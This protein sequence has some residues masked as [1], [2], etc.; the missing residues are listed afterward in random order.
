MTFSNLFKPNHRK[1]QMACHWAA[2]PGSRWRSLKGCLPTQRARTP[3]FAPRP[4][5]PRSGSPVTGVRLTPASSSLGSAPLSFSPLGLKFLCPDR[6]ASLP[7]RGT[8]YSP[9]LPTC[10]H[11]AAS[12]S[13]ARRVA[14][15][16]TNFP[17]G[18]RDAPRRR[19]E[20]PGSAVIASLCLSPYS[21]PFSTPI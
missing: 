13:R 3:A 5:A 16:G 17:A 8:A 19:L 21:S 1:P 7:L 15:G 2:S 20:N 12:G 10:P 6:C 11:P 18:Q 4:L 9:Q 14:A